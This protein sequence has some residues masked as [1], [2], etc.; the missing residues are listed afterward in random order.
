MT[1]RQPVSPPEEDGTESRRPYRQ[2]GGDLVV[3][4]PRFV[5]LSDEDEQRALTALAELLAPLFRPVDGN[6]EEPPD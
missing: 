3:H 5:P 6:S 4:P 2:P 1:R